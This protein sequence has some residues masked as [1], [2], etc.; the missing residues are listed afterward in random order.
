MEQE[1]NGPWPLHGNDAVAPPMAGWWM[2]WC[3]D[4][5]PLTYE[6]AKML[7]W[8]GSRWFDARGWHDP[9]VG[10]WAGRADIAMPM[11]QYS[12]PVNQ[13][14]LLLPATARRPQVND[15]IRKRILGLPEQTSLPFVV[16]SSRTKI[17]YIPKV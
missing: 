17:T 2:A 7:W 1:L 13:K 8:D 4:G 16:T 9:H 5:S 12:Y 11:T 6:T 3:N 15:L 14:E 10:W